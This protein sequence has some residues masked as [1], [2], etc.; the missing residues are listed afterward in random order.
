MKPEEF[1]KRSLDNR[2]KHKINEEKSKELQTFR[3]R[4]K[5][6]CVY[7]NPLKMIQ[8]DFKQKKKP[9]VFKMN[10][11]LNVLRNSE[12]RKKRF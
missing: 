8:R 7:N 2:G 4:K 6:F 10:K 5:E 1:K 9:S 12:Q 3:Q 11:M